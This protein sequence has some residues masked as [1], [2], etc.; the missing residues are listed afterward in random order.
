M[1]RN[2]NKK[3]WLE[4]MDFLVYLASFARPAMASSSQEIP[5]LSYF[6]D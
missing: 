2:R 5:D 4:Y 1:P 6:E 3:A